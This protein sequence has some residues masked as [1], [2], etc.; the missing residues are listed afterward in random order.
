[1]LLKLV[2][3]FNLLN[4]F[5]PQ[6]GKNMFF[7]QIEFCM[8]FNSE[9]RLIIFVTILALD[10]SFPVCNRTLSFGSYYMSHILKTWRNHVGLEKLIIWSYVKMIRLCRF[11]IFTPHVSIKTLL[12]IRTLYTRFL[13][14]TIFPQTGCLYENAVAWKDVRSLILL[15]I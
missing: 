6:G 11:T 2:F 12:K 13:F 4:I 10:F 3:D 14:W 9:A 7:L 5:W 15:L 1:M 8:L